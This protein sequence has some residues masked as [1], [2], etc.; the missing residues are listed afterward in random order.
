MTT[1]TT[2]AGAK[3]GVG[4][5]TVA[6]LYALSAAR[7]GQFI[8]LTATAAAGVDDLASILGVPV[9]APGGVAEAAPD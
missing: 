5:S 4:T 1:D 8:R 9:P 3:G 7:S 2:F 6:A